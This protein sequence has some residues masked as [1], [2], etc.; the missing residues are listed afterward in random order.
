MSENKN[1]KPVVNLKDIEE[2]LNLQIEEVSPHFLELLA[3][4]IQA[5]PTNL[6][7]ICLTAVSLSAM[8]MMYMMYT[9]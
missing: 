9:L 1:N 5:N 3:Q 4:L 6:A 7:V 8:Y 2:K